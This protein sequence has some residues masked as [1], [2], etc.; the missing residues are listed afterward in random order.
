[1]GGLIFLIDNLIEKIVEKKNPTVVGLDT[2]LEYIPDKILRKYKKDE[3]MTFEEAAQAILAFNKMLIDAVYEYVPGVKVQIAYYEMYG[4]P[5]L[6]AFASTCRYAKEKKLIVI[7]DVKRNDIGSTAKAYASAYLGKT[8]LI[9]N[10]KEA[11]DLDFITV[12]P[13][14]GIDG[15]LPFIEECKTYDKG[16]FIL[17][18]TSNPS[19]TDFQDLYVGEK[20]LY[21]VVANKVSEWGKELIG[22]TG[23][24][25]IGAV[26]GA[27]HP[28]QAEALRQDMPHTYFL[29]PGYGAQGGSAKDICGCFDR[30]GLG[31]VVNASRSIICAY[32]NDKWREK[33]TPDQFAEAA[34]AEVLT[35]QDNI[36]Q[37][38]EQSGKAYW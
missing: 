30:R 16:I 2:R 11:F 36:N 32:K 14:L 15:I 18:K 27:T 6:E 33:F 5:G 1:M 35:M 10:S 3:Y 7:G 13:Y 25:S 21:E 19:S 37:T 23:Y 24:S 28:R 4:P 8:N 38:L 17:V 34:L 9:D 31:A 29:V 26:V 22:K 12:N 20:M